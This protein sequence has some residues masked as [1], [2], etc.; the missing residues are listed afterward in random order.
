MWWKKLSTARARPGNDSK[1]TGHLAPCPKPYSYTWS[2]N[3]QSWS[4]SVLNQQ[5]DIKNQSKNTQKVRNLSKNPTPDCTFEIPLLIPGP[6]GHLMPMCERNWKLKMSSFLFVGAWAMPRI[7]YLSCGVP[8][9]FWTP[10]NISGLISV[11]LWL[12]RWKVI[13]QISG[14]S[15]LSGGPNYFLRSSSF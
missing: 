3:I 2:K 4:K 11:V 7:L 1:P 13:K 15:L 14:N 8:F 12:L 9:P 5:K 10:D 6:T